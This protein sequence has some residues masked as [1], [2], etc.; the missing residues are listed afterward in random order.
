MTWLANLTGDISEP[1]RPFWRRVLDPGGDEGAV[2][3]EKNQGSVRRAPIPALDRYLVLNYCLSP[4]SLS[5][6]L[7]TLGPA[8]PLNSLITVYGEQD[9]S[10]LK[11]HRLASFCAQLHGFCCLSIIMSSVPPS[12]E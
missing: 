1:R 6:H 5:V 12:E 9:T 11:L 3:E 7:P 10:T 4:P 8:L 2:P